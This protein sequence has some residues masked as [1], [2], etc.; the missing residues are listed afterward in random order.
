MLGETVSVPSSCTVKVC[1][2][3]RNAIEP[4]GVSTIH[5]PPARM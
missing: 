4:F 3:F 1:P 2:L 5:L